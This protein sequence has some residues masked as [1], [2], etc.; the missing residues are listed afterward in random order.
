MLGLHTPAGGLTIGQ[1]GI[2]YI[3]LKNT[4]SWEVRKRRY[5]PLPPG[6]IVDNQVADEAGLLALVKEWVKRD[7]LRGS[8][9]AL[10]IP[11][12]QIVIRKMTIPSGNER[13][14]EQ[15]VKLEVETGLH[16]P[17]ENPVYDY[18][19]T[20]VEEDSSKLLVFAAPRR[21]I[22]SYVDVLEQAGLRV[23]SVEFTAT[24]LARSL[25]VALGESFGETML[26]NLEDHVLDVFMFKDGNPL[27]MRSINLADL[28]RPFA[29]AADLMPGMEE[30]AA[31]AEPAPE[32]LSPEQMV[33]IT[34]EISR[35]LNFYQYSLHDGNTRIRQ[36]LVA[37]SPFVRGQLVE[38]L[39]Q[40]QAEMEVAM[41]G[42]YHTSTGEPDPELND[43]R[44]ALGAALRAHGVL[45]IN[46]LPREDR[47]ARVFPYVAGSLALLWVLGAIG[48]S[49]LFLTDRGK[50]DEGKEMIQGAED[51]GI[52]LQ[53]EMAKMNGT[54][55]QLNRKAAIGEIMKYKMNI[56]NVLNELTDGL[57]AGSVLRTMDY[58]YLT[59][60]DLT[61]LVPSME[62]SARYLAALREMSFTVDASITKLSQGDPNAEPGSP[63]S[64]SRMYTAV[65]KVNLDKR[66]AGDATDTGSQE[67]GTDSGTDQ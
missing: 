24:A 37:G 26:V 27:F 1:T 54:A 34:A 38:E 16:L 30:A 29:G 61:V 62:D 6:L 50:V 40:T 13:Q 12:S 46:L 28:N 39:R 51:R 66:G 53:A 22:Q 64:A 7:G 47:E 67:G 45:P 18:I 17:F 57:P 48:V 42:V 35:M 65:Y 43:Y 10:T 14:V 58:T 52:M 55:G 5:L 4:K 32:H 2:R 9:V 59:S 3:S 44:V 63:A 41:T 11:P 60:L 36:V 56:V 15:L 19:T 31:A 25:S 21:P 20:E 33:E 23:A 8:R 49:L